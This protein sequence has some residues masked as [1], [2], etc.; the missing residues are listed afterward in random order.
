MFAEFNTVALAACAL[1]AAAAK[2]GHPTMPGG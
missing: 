1:K 2:I